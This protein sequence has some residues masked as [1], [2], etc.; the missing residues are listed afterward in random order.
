[1]NLYHLS[2]LLG[3]DEFQ[4]FV[5]A[6]LTYIWKHMH[7]SVI[8][9]SLYHYEDNGKLQVNPVLKNLLKTKGFKWKTVTNEAKT[10]SRVEIMECNNT[11]MK[12]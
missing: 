7:C 2:T 4:S 6:A 3:D 12:G 1:M 9:L 5:D 10:G 11:T 8:R